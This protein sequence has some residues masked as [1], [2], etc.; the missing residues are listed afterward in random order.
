MA[1]LWQVLVVESAARELDAVESE[2]VREDF[3]ALLPEF[4]ENGP[5]AYGCIPLKNIR[6]TGARVRHRETAYEGL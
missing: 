2:D 5:N 3:Y 6:D 4:V 1:K